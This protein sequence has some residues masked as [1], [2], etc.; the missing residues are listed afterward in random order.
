[1]AGNAP[2]KQDANF[3]GFYIARE[4]TLKQLPAN[5]VF[6]EREPNSFSDLGA[7]YAKVVRSPF[8]ASRQRKKGTNS[9]LDVSGGWNE[10]LTQNNMQGDFE[11]FCFAA[12]RRKGFEAVTAVDATDD[13][14]AVASIAGFAVGDLV[15]G[16][17]FRNGANNGLHRVSAVAAGKITVASALVTEATVIGGPAKLDIAGHQF[18]AGDLSLSV[19]GGRAYLAS[20]AVD[21]RNFGLIPGEWCAV[22]GDQAVTH[23]DDVPPFYARISE[24]TEDGVYFDKTTVAIEDDAGAAKTV[25]LFFGYLVRNEDDP[26]NIVRF[27]HVVERTLGKDADGTQSEFL[28]GFVFNEMTWTSPLANKVSIDITGVGLGYTKR[29]GVD[30]P[31]HKDAGTVTKKA[32]GEDAFNTS[33]NVYRIRL[34]IVDQETLN[35]TPMFARCTE[36]NAKITNNVSAAKAQG[37]Y[38]GFDTTIGQFDVL[39]SVTAYFSTVEACQAIEDNEDTTFDAIYAKDNAAIIM[40]IPLISPG[41]GRLNVEQNAAIMLPLSGDGAESPFGHTF[42]LNWLPY[43]PDALMPTGA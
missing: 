42:L 4:E 17:G 25:Q 15:A 14:F 13:H 43:V 38:G 23:F 26:D 39:L 5:P 24:V 29:K 12:M 30:G 34:S 16:Y 8:N 40:D 11:A 41:G 37:S 36:W 33:R 18:A 35:P 22:G 19:V 10:D 28:K 27:T 1:M 20:A 7:E 31:A 9:D 2:E 21:M 3:V 6:I 32:L